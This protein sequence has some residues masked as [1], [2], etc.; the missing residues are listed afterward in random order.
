MPEAH[1]MRLLNPCVSELL[2]LRL[3]LLQ[4]PQLYIYIYIYIYIHCKKK[5]PPSKSLF[6]PAPLATH[7]PL[8]PQHSGIQQI[9]Q[10]A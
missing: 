2:T 5:E 10:H 7:G 6:S 9:S 4:S 3:N 8:R 1:L